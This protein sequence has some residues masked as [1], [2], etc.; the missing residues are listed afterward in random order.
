MGYKKIVFVI[1]FLAIFGFLF[2]FGAPTAKAMTAAEIQALIQQLQQ[3]IAQLQQ[4]LSEIQGKPAAW[5]HDFTFNLKYGD[6]SNEVNLLQLA[7]DKEGV[8]V[9]PTDR[10]GY[11]GDYT[12][13]AVVAFQ[14]KYASEI[15][16]PWGL[17]HGTGFVGSTTRAKLNELYGCKITCQTLWWYDND[18]RYCQQKQFCGAYMYLGLYT[19]KTKEECEASLLKPSITVLSP[20][21]GE[22]WVMGEKY[23]IKLSNRPVKCPTV[24]ADCRVYS[25]QLIDENK[26]YVGTISCGYFTPFEAVS[27]IKT[28]FEWDTRTVLDCCGAGCQSQEVKPGKYKIR[29][30]DRYSPEI[31]DESDNYFSIIEKGA[32]SITVTYPTA[33]EKLQKGNNTFINLQFSP[34]VPKG[35]FVVNLLRSDADIAVAHLKYCGTTG[36]TQ[37]SANPINV[38]W[39][40]KVGYDADGKEIPDGSYRIFVYDCGD[41]TDPIWTGGVASAKSGIFSIVSPTTPSITVISP[42]GGERW[43]KGNTYEIKWKTLGDGINSVRI[44]LNN[45]AVS[46]FEETITNN[47]PNTGSFQWKIPSDLL[48]PQPDG[49]VIRIMECYYSKEVGMTVCGDPTDE[50][51]NYFSIVSAVTACTDS[52]GGLNYYV[53]GTVELSGQ[54][55]VDYCIDN[56][57][58]REYWCTGM[59][60]V[61]WVNGEDYTCPYGC[62]DGACLPGITVLSPNGGEKWVIGNTYNITWSSKGVER[63]YINLLDSNG[64]QAWVAGGIGA[65]LGKYAWTIPSNIQTGDRSK[66][67]ITQEEEGFFPTPQDVSD[68]YFSILEFPPSCTYL[69]NGITESFGTTCGDEKYDPVFDLN[70]DKWITG[71]DRSLLYGH[72]NDEGWCNEMKNSTV[73][74]C[75]EATSTVGLKSIENQLASI[76]AAVSQLMENIKELMRR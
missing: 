24:G 6:D 53:K 66:I 5:C 23:L 43:V 42:N 69:Q 52:D 31:V 63:V 20:N 55:N 3:Q 36:Y 32:P 17:K 4:Q 50:S 57:T 74:P 72:I 38:S 10:G 51:D 11:F 7:L 27:Q 28:E 64:A 76:S 19:F 41:K 33:G 8:Y 13:S 35:G 9:S 58:L 34:S 30:A 39:T 54:K 70:K 22:Q 47:Y 40:W 45:K 12:A 48:L 67:I 16:A 37:D 21:G 68:N 1:S 56:N 49:Y 26:N 71:A 15:L 60:G 65:S 14:E 29:I 44:S 2:N 59:G 46:A 61:E 75:L 25:I 62:K 18:H 73:N